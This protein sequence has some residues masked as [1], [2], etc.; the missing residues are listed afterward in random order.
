MTEN[1]KEYSQLYNA[2]AIPEKYNDF[3]IELMEPHDFFWLNQK[4]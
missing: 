3:Y 2:D 1:K 4:N